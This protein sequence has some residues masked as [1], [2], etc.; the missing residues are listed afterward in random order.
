VNHNNLASQK[1]LEELAAE[2]ATKGFICS[3]CGACC[4][5][6]EAM[7]M[8]SP[9]EIR[10]LTSV[11]ALAW[12]EVVQPYPEYILKKKKKITFGWVLR[13]KGGSC[14]FLKNDRCIVYKSRPWICKTYPFMLDNA[15]SKHQLLVSECEG[16]DSDTQQSSE[17]SEHILPLVH[18][19]IA[20]SN[21]EKKEQD[22]V[23]HQY[24]RWKKEREK[25]KHS[26]KKHSIDWTIV[27]DSEG[28]TYVNS[29]NING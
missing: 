15:S 4:T 6:E 10:D 20:R 2:I 13:H 17:Q 8:V 18:D 28:V 1:R 9:P 22:G 7:V 27:I 26:G 16:L 29:S 3:S 25:P 12:D 24:Q 14:I 5:G 23:F 11:S 19:L 21:A